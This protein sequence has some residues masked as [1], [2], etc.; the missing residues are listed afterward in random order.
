[1]RNA[2]VHALLLLS[3]D[4]RIAGPHSAILLP[5]LFR[6]FA[7]LSGSAGNGN[8]REKDAA[9]H[10]RC[11]DFASF[12]HIYVPFCLGIGLIELALLWRF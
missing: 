9:V 4:A 5:G 6:C 10:Y 7:G 1:M 3:P 12:W 11:A 8:G 2:P